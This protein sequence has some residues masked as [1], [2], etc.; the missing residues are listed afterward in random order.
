MY[1]VFSMNKR[2]NVGLR[3]DVYTRLKDQGRFGESFS[4]LV[5]RIID[6]ANKNTLFEAGERLK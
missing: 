1:N 5:S 6:V 3:F 4:D 2:V